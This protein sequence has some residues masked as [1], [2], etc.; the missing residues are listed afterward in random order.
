MAY[1][2]P[3]HTAQVLRALEGLGVRNLHVF[4][5]GAKSDADREAVEQT[6]RLCRSLPW[7]RL[8]YTESRENRGLAKS[9]MGAADSILERHE[10]FVLL[11][12]DCVPQKHFMEYM[13]RCLERYRD[14]PKVYGI[15]G[16]SVPLGESLL[17]RYPHDVY[18]FPRIGSW[19]WA[20]WKRA[21][22]ELDRDLLGAYR[23]VMRGQ[24][25]IHQGG[26]DVQ[27][28]VEGMLGNR[29]K[30]VWTLN[31]ILTVY[32]RGGVYVYPR[33]SH[34]DNI[35]FD[36]TGVHCGATDKYDTVFADRPPVDLPGEAKVDPEIVRR[37]RSFYDLG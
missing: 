15:S 8:T 34:V 7:A 2:R 32:A 30:D 35:G 3:G 22:K 9:I 25:D 21:W 13:A 19:G 33:K 20:T 12:D 36:G 6:R 11:E 1:K 18:F 24:A 27:A 5:D 16:Y 4:S 37:V 14:N 26:N 23:T 31:W 28:M 10:H 17:R 29:V